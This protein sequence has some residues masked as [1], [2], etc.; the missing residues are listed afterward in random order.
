MNFGLPLEAVLSAYSIVGDDAD[1][2]VN[3]VYE[4]FG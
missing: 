1:L 4:N 2:I 3:Y